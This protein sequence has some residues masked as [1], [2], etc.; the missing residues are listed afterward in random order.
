MHHKVIYYF[1]EVTRF[2]YRNLL[3][4][5][6]IRSY[7]RSNLIQLVLSTTNMNLIHMISFLSNPISEKCSTIS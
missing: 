5:E 3:H 1:W 4:L 6:V 2:N 7:L